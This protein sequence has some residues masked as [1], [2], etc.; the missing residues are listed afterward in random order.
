MTEI[1]HIPA[2]LN[3]TIDGLNIQ[4]NGIYVDATFGGG[5]HSR[6]I[7]E[8]LSSGKLIAFDQDSD[9]KYNAWNADNFVLI[10]ANFSYIK[11][12]LQYLKISQIDGVVADLGLSTHHIDVPERG[13]SFRFDAKLDMR[14][15]QKQELDAFFVVNNYEQEKLQDIF[16]NFGELKNAKQL[17]NAIVSARKQ[18]QIETTLDLVKVLEKF[19]PKKAEQ[20]FLSKIFQAIRIE[21]NDEIETLKKFLLDAT[22]LLKKNGRIAII[23]YH[24]LEDKIVKNFFK[25]GNF[26]GQ[27][28]TDM[29]G[30]IIRPLTPINNK[31]IVPTE[32]E[33]N[34]NNRVRSAKLRIA[35]KC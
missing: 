3:E 14:M 22:A 15:N 17:A 28:K 13:F 26:D 8:K 35:E 9:A 23:S 24:S 1:Y 16:R 10:Q 6:K 19:I 2:L 33:I 18:K 4:N 31:V 25:T 20:K 11:N 7:F 12:F 27:R 34:K 5:G 21:V 30:N 32:D 29:Y